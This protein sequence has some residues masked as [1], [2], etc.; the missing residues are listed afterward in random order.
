MQRPGLACHSLRPSVHPS[1]TIECWF[2]VRFDYLS[3]LARQGRR[4][5]VLGGRPSVQGEHRWEGSATAPS[6]I[7]RSRPGGRRAGRVMRVSQQGPPAVLGRD[8]ISQPHAKLLH[9]RSE[10]PHIHAYVA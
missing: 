7:G 5:G 8:Q 1:I 10:W 9:I 2:D 6:L 3:E 4:G